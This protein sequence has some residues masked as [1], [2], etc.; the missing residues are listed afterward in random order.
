MRPFSLCV[1]ALVLSGCGGNGTGPP[2]ETPAGTGSL[3]VTLARSPGSS[4]LLFSASVQVGAG[5]AIRVKDW[6]AHTI[7][8]LTAGVHQVD[9]TDPT[10]NCSIQGAS[11]KSV[12]ITANQVAEVTFQISCTFQPQPRIVFQWRKEHWDS[13]AWTVAPDGT[14]LL[15]LTQKGTRPFPCWSPDGAKMVFTGPGGSSQDVEVWV[16]NAD[17]SGAK[18]LTNEPAGRSGHPT[19]SHNGQKIVYC[20][21]PGMLMVMNADGTQQVAVTE[22][23]Q[24]GYPAWSPNDQ[25]IVFA[26]YERGVPQ[27][28]RIQADGTGLSKLTSVEGG[29]AAP[30]YLRDGSG[31]T[32]HCPEAPAA[33]VERAWIMDVDGG[34]QRLFEPLSLN[35]VMHWHWWQ[36]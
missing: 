13:D 10:P 4:A 9:A 32:F 19:W 34:N 36:Q 21:D 5:S 31:I 35:G 8:G 26:R 12:S 7:G 29:C 3:V 25:E 15:Q 16:M 33:P 11:S 23:A 6:D 2:D 18:A 17:G 24:C 14:N 20:K 22:G 28:W 1:L 30:L 27:V